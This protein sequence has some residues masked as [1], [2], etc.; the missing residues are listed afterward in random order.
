MTFVAAIVY[1]L[2]GAVA[3]WGAFCV[4]IVW[5]RVAEKRFRSE[6]LQGEFLSQLGK[7]LERGDFQL[8]ARLLDGDIRALPLL[9]QM[10]IH[11]RQLGYTKVRKL[12]LD[13]FQRDILSDLD[14]RLSWIN[15]VIK[16][17]PMLGL[18]GTVLGMMG[19]FG[20]LAGKQNVNPDVLA[21]DISFALITTALGL[22]IAI[23]L[24]L[25]VASITVRIRKFEELVASGMAHFFESF[26]EGLAKTAPKE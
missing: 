5:R 24:I 25:C 26:R 13:R 17:A 7:P 11:N 22:S 9:A 19:A 4:V 6:Q 21:G 10:A 12:V 23:P 1:A 18:L 3:L 20:K 14:Q 2:I 8:A 15:T 16:S